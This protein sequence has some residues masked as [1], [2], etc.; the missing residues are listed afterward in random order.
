MIFLLDVNVVIALLDP[1]HINHHVAHN[2][3]S[4]EA[5][6]AFATCPLTENGALRIMGHPRYPNSPGG[7]ASVAPKLA[8]LCRLPGHSFWPDDFS[9]LGPSV[10]RTRLLAS[11]QVTDSYLLGLAVLNGGELATLDRRIIPSAIAGGEQALHV[12]AAKASDPQ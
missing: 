1:L 3:F 10:D 7:P 4:A 2:W 9:L 8:S 12:I 11:A 5:E 6:S